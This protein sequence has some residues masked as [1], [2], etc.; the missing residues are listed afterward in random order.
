MEAVVALEEHHVG[1]VDVADQVIQTHCARVPLSRGTPGHPEIAQTLNPQVISRRLG[2]LR[3][4]LGETRG[5]VTGPQVTAETS[6]G[7]MWPPLFSLALD[8]L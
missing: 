3:G 5:C 7:G 1:R 2:L 6:S 8:I 4:F